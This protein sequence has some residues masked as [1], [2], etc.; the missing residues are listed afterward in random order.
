MTARN[1]S[2]KVEDYG[3][4]TAAL[5]SST[6][7]TF[8]HESPSSAESGTTQ[9][10]TKST[11]S[12]PSETA[13]SER[14]YTSAFDNHTPTYSTLVSAIHT[15]DHQT[16]V[17]TFT[18]NIS[19]P[20]RTAT[21]SYTQ[22]AQANGYASETFSSS[23][24]QIKPETTQLNSSHSNNIYTPKGHPI[25]FP[26]PLFNHSSTYDRGSGHSSSGN[27][28]PN[29]ASAPQ[30]HE[31]TSTPTTT[32]NSMSSSSKS[33]SESSQPTAM[34]TSSPGDSS[35]SPVT[36]VS[37]PITS[38]SSTQSSTGHDTSPTCLLTGL[39]GVDIAQTLTHC[40]QTQPTGTQPSKT[41]QV[42]YNGRFS[43]LS[44]YC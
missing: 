28:P 12:E 37:P 6:S 27:T 10:S 23:V 11:A 43:G 17:F 4:T 9:R 13:E 35:S 16:S 40:I 32:A 42:K 30:R 39:P 31:L 34:R 25:P 22:S 7:P 1:G 20:S 41:T 33:T 26:Q 29:S 14:T 2:R 21:I 15:K 36:I 44:L 24:P 38:T 8:A 18:S 5:A 3:M 19:N